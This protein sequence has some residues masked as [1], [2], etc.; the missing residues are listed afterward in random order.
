MDAHLSG[1][2]ASWPTKERLA[3]ILCDGGLKVYVGRYSIR[4]ENCSRFIFQEY[5]GDLGD[6]QIDAEADTVEEMILDGRL[7]SNALARAGLV[8]RFEIYQDDDSEMAGYLHH[9]WP[10]EEPR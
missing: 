6:P 8:H 9:K 3:K 4:V 10:L 2:L 7:V 5:G 1:E